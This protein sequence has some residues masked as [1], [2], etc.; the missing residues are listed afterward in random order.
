MLVAGNKVKVYIQH[1][2]T[3][4]IGIWICAISERGQR[5]YMKPVAKE[6]GYV[7]QAVDEGAA[8]PVEPTLFFPDEMANELLLGL[9]DELDR[10]T[11]RTKRDQY[12]EGKLD[13]TERHLEDTQGTIANLFYLCGQMA[14]VEPPTPLGKEVRKK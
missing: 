2:P 14:N 9:R 3:G 11:V 8:P 7:M 12:I 10:H 6:G 5:H 13:A 1:L 4:G